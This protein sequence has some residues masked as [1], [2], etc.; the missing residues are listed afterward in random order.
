[1]ATPNKTPSKRENR[2]T[3]A[4]SSLTREKAEAAKAY[5]EQKYSKLKREESERKEGWEQLSKKMLDLNLS[6]T[7]QQLIKQEILHKEAEQLRQRRRRTSV[8][9]FES[10]AIIGRGAFGE[11]RVVRSRLTGEILAMKKMNKSEMV[12][13][14]QVQHVRR[15]TFWPAAPVL[16][17]WI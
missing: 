3:V 11:V 15:G 12:Y 1:M 6:S 10:I 4:V 17:S 2:D 7:E 8:Y 14:N 5:I 16:G 9:D 13:K